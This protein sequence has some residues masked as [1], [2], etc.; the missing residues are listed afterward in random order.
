[1]IVY[2]ANEMFWDLNEASGC[3]KIRVINDG[4]CIAVFSSTFVRDA[5]TWECVLVPMG[6]SFNKD[7]TFLLKDIIN[8]SEKIM[9]IM[10]SDR[11]SFEEIQNF[12]LT[13]IASGV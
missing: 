11:L 6:L 2:Q 13:E 12:I 8:N 4:E 9:N 5:S 10:S 1:M 3:R 7:E